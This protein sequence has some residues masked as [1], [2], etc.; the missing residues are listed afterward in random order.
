MAFVGLFA[1]A[2][3]LAPFFMDFRGLWKRIPMAL[4]ALVAPLGVSVS[5]PSAW[6][7]LGAILLAP[8]V[9]KSAR[10][11]WFSTVFVA[12]VL[13]GI[14]T[15]WVWS[16]RG[17]GS[18]SFGIADLRV[19]SSLLC[20][21]LMFHA[22]AEK[23]HEA[24]TFLKIFV[25]GHAILCFV[26]I[27]GTIVSA[28]I[29]ALFTY[30]LG[31]VMKVNPNILAS[32]LDVAAPISAG[33]ALRNQENRR[34]KA[35][36]FLITGLLFASTILSQSRGALLG[37]VV[38]AL[39]FWWALFMRFP[40]HRLSLLA[41]ILLC[42]VVAFP[43]VQRKVMVQSPSSI[44]SNM[45]RV[46]LL[47]KA[48]EVLKD[49]EYF[50]GGGI[51]AFKS[52]KMQKGFP[53]WFDPTA[54]M[55]SHNIHLE[56]LLGWGVLG[57]LAWLLLLGWLGWYAARAGLNGDFLGFGS[58]AAIGAFWIHGMVDSLLVLPYFLLSNCIV[59]GVVLAA[60]APSRNLSRN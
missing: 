43:V 50:Y 12:L 30:R 8:F 48:T 55:S 46:V 36:W 29:P 38:I 33:M 24:A 49:Q 18:F 51:D 16:M 15:S 56:F 21:Y 26:L 42:V 17:V 10:I 5:H 20:G 37:L 40:R 4:L 6:L 28:G 53:D 47:Q 52:L 19:L 32:L 35:V 60:M 58:L 54:Q 7:P 45:G 23:P 31:S 39:V 34:V 2:V 41:L 14:G 11:G 9:I 59:A 13:A 57:L 22:Y 44:V 25:L 3:L 1:L 27:S